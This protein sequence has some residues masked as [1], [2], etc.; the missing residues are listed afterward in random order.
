MRRSPGTR[1]PPPTFAPSRCL[2]VSCSR[3]PAPRR[4]A[5]PRRWRFSTIGVSRC[6]A[7]A[8]ARASATVRHLRGPAA[9]ACSRAGG[10]VAVHAMSATIRSGPAPAA[11]PVRCRARA[12]APA[13]HCQPAMRVLLEGVV[14][15]G[16]RCCPP[17]PVTGR[18]ASTFETCPMVG[19]A[20]LGLGLGDYCR[21]S[22]DRP[23]PAA[24]FHL[25]RR[26]IAGGR[27]CR[28]P[29][30]CAGSRADSFVALPGSNA[31]G[32]QGRVFQAVHVA[33]GVA[34]VSRGRGGRC[35]RRIPK[36]LQV[37][38]RRFSGED[39]LA[40]R[41][42]VGIRNS[43]ARSSPGHH[44]PRPWRSTTPGQQVVVERLDEHDEDSDLA[45]KRTTGS[46]GCPGGNRREERRR[47]RRSRYRRSNAQSGTPWSTR[48]ISTAARACRPTGSPLDAAGTPSRRGAALRR[49]KRREDSGADSAPMGIAIPS[50]FCS[51]SSQLQPQQHHE[52]ERAQGRSRRGGSRPEQLP[53]GPEP[54]AD[55]RVQHARRPGQQPRRPP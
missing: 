33:E 46:P 19:A 34:P 23:G 30:P 50:R 11:C 54:E 26:S 18:N 6:R 29:P 20:A 53:V 48:I 44:G 22:A 15:S 37:P 13:G 36:S 39:A 49:R 28:S 31:P 25:R 47:A 16:P 27:P 3:T 5:A 7:L 17:A 14:A 40:S 52:E 41:R 4:P 9:P 1:L 35:H 2:V 42:A 12:G 32:G 38:R 55:R 51:G 45:Q 24:H 43:N 10:V 8:D 21:A